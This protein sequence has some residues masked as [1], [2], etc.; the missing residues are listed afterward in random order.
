MLFF[1]ADGMRQ[2]L[3]EQFSATRTRG[4]SDLPAFAE[5]LKKGSSASG[6]GLLTQAPPNTG[7][8]WYS[9]ATGAWP[10]VHGSTNNTFHVNGQPFGNST[11]AFNAGVPQAESIGQSAE[12]GGKKVVQFEYAGGA[13]TAIQ[14]PTVDFRTFHSGR[15]VATN[16]ISPNDAENFVAAFGVQFDHP[17]GFA[18]QAAFP[19]AAPAAAIGWTNT[20]QSF[21]PAKEMRLR[22]LDFGV[23]KYGLNV[24][25]FDST[26]DGRVNYDKVLFSPTK[27]GSN[28]VGTLGQGE[29]ADVKVKISG[30]ALD[31]K[32]A[33]F[34]VK[35]ETLT[36]DLSQVRLFHTSVARAIAS[37]P[38]WPGEPGFTGAFDEYLAQTFPS[39]TAADFAVLESGVVSEETYVEQGLKWETFATPVLTYITQAYQP[40]LALVGYPTTDEFQH[41][42]LGLTV[43][44]LPNGAPNPAYDDVQVN[45]TPDGRVAQRTEFIRS[46]YRGADRFM[47]LAQNLLDEPTTFVASDHGFAPQFAAIDAS[48]VL[49]DLG[50]LSKPQTGELSPSGGRDDRQGQGLLGRRRR[51]DLPQPRRA[52]PGGRRAA[53]G[54][55]GRRG[56][57][58]RQD[59]GGVP[60]TPGSQ[61]LDR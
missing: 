2:D 41:Q 48:K 24:Y 26:D 13:E 30:G 60:R 18:G 56:V 4:R 36:A 61:R 11:S 10:G 23:D 50:L 19:G 20:P 35:V 28:S 44:K 22:V 27:D 14:G 57:D 37:W 55:R 47:T 21:S 8:G 7:A 16:Y 31:G 59:Q 40:D 17:A 15:G 25:L 29:W 51:A 42:F 39:S 46:A 6:G 1:V 32:T 53:A 54:P 43:P 38:T 49:V 5:L 3:V 12:R 45:G 52:R 33:G 34:L 58:R 9:L